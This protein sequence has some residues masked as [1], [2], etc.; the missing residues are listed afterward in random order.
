MS[1]AGKISVGAVVADARPASVANTPLLSERPV[2]QSSGES[3]EAGVD[4]VTLQA[5][6]DSEADKTAKDRETKSLLEAETERVA[7]EIARSS[8][9]TL[10]R[11][12]SMQQMER[13]GNEGVRFR[14]VDRET[15]EVVR[16]FPQDE[17]L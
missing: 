7:A 11:F 17:V 4:R 8:R 9:W 15:G 16:E 13:E 10:V 5:T 14:V 1:N 2:S 6:V 3:V 12:E